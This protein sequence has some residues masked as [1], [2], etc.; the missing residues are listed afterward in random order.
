MKLNLSVLAVFVIANTGSGQFTCLKGDCQNGYGEAVFPSGAKYAGE[1]RSG[2]LHGLGTMYFPEGHR[3]S[4]YWKNQ[5]REGQGRF[6]FASGDEYLGAF[7]HNQMEGKGVM[8]YAN[9]NVYKG[10]WAGNLPHGPGEMSMF[11]GARYTGYFA[12]GNFEG[13][14]IMYYADGSRYSGLWKKGMRSGYGTLV[15]PDGSIREGL[16][17]KNELQGAVAVKQPE[18]HLADSAML[19]NCNKEFCASGR[20]RYS[21]SNGNV[22]VGSF[23]NGVP[24]GEG[25]VFY[26]SG[27]WYEGGWLNHQPQGKGTMFYASGRSLRAFWASGRPIQTP[28]EPSVPNL[29]AGN[30]TLPGNPLP[31]PRVYAVVVGVAQ[32]PHMP[33][34]RYTD[35]DAYRMSLLLRSPE[36]GAVPESQVHLLIDEGA[37]SNAVL[38]ALRKAAALAGEN[39]LLMFYFSGH[40]KEGAF[41]PVDF[42][43]FY[44]KLN[45]ETIREIMQ[46]SRAKHKLVVADACHAGN[47]YALRSGSV[48]S[49]L[50]KYYSALAN[51]SGGFALLLSSKGEEYSL[52]DSGLRSGVYSH[53]LIKGAGG[54]ADH[55]G[56]GIVTVREIHDFLFQK[57]RTYTAGAQTPLLLGEFD[58]NMPFG[59]VRK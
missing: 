42:D 39:D 57:V 11:S 35:D 32:Y 19:R 59:A 13:E 2:R 56:D 48:Q 1:F 50:E 10:E 25:R 51:S 4:G 14:G 27:D 40:G 6:T 21:Y 52:E 16:W 45:H 34:L 28:D 7:L 9:G 26:P 3:Y 31:A 41:L 8:T 58:P 20:G 47:A 46:S 24:E 54:A 29:S 53:F 23:R 38:N 33:A 44:N 49:V 12:F 15:S 55:N 18:A 5:Y 22:Y 36:G 17:E 37:T 43:G 30:R